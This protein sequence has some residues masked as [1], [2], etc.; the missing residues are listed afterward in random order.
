M[1]FWPLLADLIPQAVVQPRQCEEILS[2]ALHVFR[3]LADTFI[4]SVDIESCLVKWGAL[5]VGYEAQEVG[6]IMRA[7]RFML[8]VLSVR[9]TSRKS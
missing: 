6:W 3:K 2:V 5:L 1:F 4:E 9:W 8:I 7:R